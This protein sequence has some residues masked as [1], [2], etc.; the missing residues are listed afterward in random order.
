MNLTLPKL[1]NDFYLKLRESAKDPLKSLLFVSEDFPVMDCY[2]SCYLMALH[3]FKNTNHTS[4]ELVAGYVSGGSEVIGH[5]WLEVEGILVDITSEQYNILREEELSSNILD[6]R[7]FLP[8]YCIDVNLASH[9]DIFSDLTREVI[10][11]SF[12]QLTR[13]GYEEWEEEYF[14]ILS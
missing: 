8:I 12:S 6:R 14:K 5:C 13:S 2:N 7:P 4:I 3:I 9:H 1:V 10:D 11:R